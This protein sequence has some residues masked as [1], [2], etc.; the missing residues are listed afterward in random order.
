[1]T[2]GHIGKH[3]IPGNL[4]LRLLEKSGNCMWSGKWS[5]WCSGPV[6]L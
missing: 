2:V 4:C 6:F 1:M 5:P 3:L